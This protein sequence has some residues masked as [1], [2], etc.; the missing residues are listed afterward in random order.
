MDEANHPTV[1]REGIKGWTASRSG[2]SSSSERMLLTASLEATPTSADTVTWEHKSCRSL[3]PSATWYLRGCRNS[4]VYVPLGSSLCSSSSRLSVHSAVAMGASSLPEARF[5]RTTTSSGRNGGCMDT[6]SRMAAVSSTSMSK[7]FS[8]PRFIQSVTGFDIF[9]SWVRCLGTR[10]SSMLPM[11][12]LARLC[13]SAAAEWSEEPVAQ[14]QNC[15]SP[16][17]VN[18]RFSRKVEHWLPLLTPFALLASFSWYVPAGTDTSRLLLPE[19]I[20]LPKEAGQSSRTK[21]A[22]EDFVMILSSRLSLVSSLMKCEP[23]SGTRY[24][25]SIST[26]A[27]VCGA[28][29]S[30]G[31]TRV[32]VQSHCAVR[33]L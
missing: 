6:S 20:T 30:G 33:F 17:G 10:S 29:S 7:D 14:G 11:W 12:S 3:G 15:R 23:S 31:G 13:A 19:A 32:E 21:S 25:E 24:S 9:T 26:C 28:R 27:S 1:F 22:S 4:T 5:L 18:S 16:M 8:M 2:R